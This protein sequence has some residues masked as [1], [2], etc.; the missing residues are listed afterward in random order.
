MTEWRKPISPATS[1]GPFHLTFHFS[2]GSNWFQLVLGEMSKVKIKGF[3]MLAT[4]RFLGDRLV[5]EAPPS[6]A[7]QIAECAKGIVH[8]SGYRL[9]VARK[10]PQIELVSDYSPKDELL[11]KYAFTEVFD[12][13]HVDWEDASFDF[14]HIVTYKNPACPNYVHLATGQWP[15]LELFR[16]NLVAKLPFP[17]PAIGRYRNPTTNQF[18]VA[19]AVGYSE[20][21]PVLMTT[22]S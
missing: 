17:C 18:R 14:K 11:V 12:K 22:N 6:V 9:S 2:N 5:M 8:P 3:D 13:S 1:G 15:A 7:K 10:P 21:I 4:F 19:I 16:H 20:P